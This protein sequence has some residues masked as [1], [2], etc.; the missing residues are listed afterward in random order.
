M[1]TRGLSVE[2]GT[3]RNTDGNPDADPD[4]NVVIGDA[5]R[6]L[7]KYRRPLL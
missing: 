6:R 3:E 5:D 1:E 2:G 7:R 4:R